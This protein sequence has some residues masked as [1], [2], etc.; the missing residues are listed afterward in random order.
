M[1]PL[2]MILPTFFIIFTLC[3]SACS[4]KLIS[5]SETRITLG[6]YVQLIIVSGEKNTNAVE[7]T[8]KS[9][10]ELIYDLDNKLDY[11]NKDGALWQFNN[12]NQITKQEDEL[13]FSVLEEALNLAHLTAGYFDPTILPI[14][15]LWGFNTGNPRVPSEYEIIENLQ[16][17]GYKKVKLL[18]DRI[19][20]SENMKFDLSGIAKGKIVDNLRDYLRSENYNNFLINAGGD[21]YVGGT[22][23][24]RNKWRIAIQNPVQENQYSGVVEKSDRA[25]VTSGDYEQ[26]F[27]ENGVRYSHL[28]NPKTGY[29]FSDIKSVTIIADNTSFADAIATAVYS[30][31]SK[32][33]F[34]FL[35]RNNIKGFI[36][37]QI[38]DEK[39]SSKSTPGFWE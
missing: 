15:Q 24:D 8:I 29:P 27:I 28:F 9:A 19:L 35:T 17:I 37:Y 23:K 5:V 30:M 34:S 18:E 7:S 10:Y 6:T 38:T 32:E 12:T 11:R 1:K 25:V 20:K 36:I 33:G 2:P 26:F 3:L 16:F 22:T 39:I 31:G 14:V 13:L 21:I 4:S